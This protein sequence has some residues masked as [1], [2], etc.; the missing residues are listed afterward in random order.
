MTPPFF[1]AR[2]PA[3]AEYT[4]TTAPVQN[5]LATLA[6]LTDEQACAEL[7]PWF[8]QA[9]ASL[10]PEQRATN[11]LVFEGLGAA[12]LAVPEEADFDSYLS[13]LEQ[14]DPHELAARAQASASGDPAAEALLADP[15]ALQRRLAEHLRALHA[16]VLGAQWQRR[17][18]Q[19]AGFTIV[20]SERPPLSGGPADL[21]RAF[22]NRELPDWISAQLAGVRRV[23]FVI[24]PYIRLH[25]ARL[26]SPDTIWVFVLGNPA[27][28]PLRAAPINRREVLRPLQAL[29]DESRLQILE[30]LAQHGEVP[31]AEL[32]VQLGQS[33]PN[34]SRHLKQLIAAG[35]ADE[36]RG[37]GANKRY[38]L[39]LQQINRLFWTLRQLLAAENGR[40]AEDDPR[41]DQPLVLRRFLD[42]QSRV[43]IWPARREDRALVR[44]YLAGKFDQGREYSEPEVNQIINRWH[45]YGDH[46]TL[47]RE[48]FSAKLLGRTPDGARYWRIEAPAQ[49]QVDSEDL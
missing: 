6:L 1:A 33:Q 14:A 27:N 31:T 49:A 30:L 19:L 24:S 3:Q 12:L 41:A 44:E 26:G 5:T 15:P 42:A 37:E 32:I 25:A 39:N 18:S 34:V 20:L 28:L 21:I 8:A 29:A 35:F 36:L 4:I 13:A 16:S 17:L 46:A 47:R 22:I 11:R 7:E 9:A 38:R 23:V 48:L 43:T 2:A 40:A 45:S 10:S